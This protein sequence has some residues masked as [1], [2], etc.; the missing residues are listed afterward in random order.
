MKLKTSP[1]VF[2]EE[3]CVDRISPF[4]RSRLTFCFCLFLLTEVSCCT[5]IISILFRS[6]SPRDEPS[7]SLQSTLP[8]LLHEETCAVYSNYIM[9]LNYTRFDAV[10]LWVFIRNMNSYRS[11]CPHLDPLTAPSNRTVRAAEP[12][13]I[14][15]CCKW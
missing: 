5:T 4:I 13:C 1:P 7:F 6:A 11:C 14:I 10:L 15:I 2:A 3:T 9:C 8:P 12:N